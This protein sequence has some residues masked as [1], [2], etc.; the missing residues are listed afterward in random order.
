MP[1]KQRIDAQNLYANILEEIKLRMGIVEHFVTGQSALPS[2]FVKENC[3]LQIRMMCELIAMGCLVAHG[4]IRDSNTPK[5]QKEWSADRIMD[6]LEKLHPHF[7]PRPVRQTRTAT[8]VHFESVKS[9]L[10]KA[11]FLALYGKCGAALHRGSVR[12]LLKGQFPVQNNYP[13][14]VGHTQNIADL[15]K[16]HLLMM[17]SGEELMVGI[18]VNPADNGKVQVGIAETPKGQPIDFSS[19][20]FQREV[21]SQAQKARLC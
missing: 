17:H 19:P 18:L 3:Y 11:D 14:I 10:P 8:G 7:Y 21:A 1:T 15:L 6:A 13:E 9:P 16:V 2:P 12:K 20:Y 4:D 5:L